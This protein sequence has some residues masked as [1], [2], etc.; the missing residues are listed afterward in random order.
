MSQPAGEGNDVT[1]R[2]GTKGL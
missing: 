2:T 1:A